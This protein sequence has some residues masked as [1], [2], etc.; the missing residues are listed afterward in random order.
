MTDKLK[1]AI[2]VLKKNRERDT[3]L[4]RKYHPNAGE[5]YYNER[6]DTEEA[7][8]TVVRYFE[9]PPAESEKI[10]EILKG[11]ESDYMM[12]IE[13]LIKNQHTMTPD[14]VIAHAMS[15]VGRAYS[16]GVDFVVE[17]L[18]LEKKGDE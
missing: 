16:A 9:S 6:S 8:D 18:K 7:I 14:W 13:S 2:E 4:K 15:I 11:T 5:K 3:M 17:V 10:P 1:E 12:Q